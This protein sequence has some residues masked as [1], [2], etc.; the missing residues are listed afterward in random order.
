MRSAVFDMK[1]V[2]LLVYAPREAMCIAPAASLC[3]IFE[4]SSQKHHVTFSLQI[5]RRVGPRRRYISMP[6]VEAR[7]SPHA[8]RRVRGR[9]VL[10]K[11]ATVRNMV[12]MTT[13][14]LEKR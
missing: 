8:Q 4:A 5:Q 6:R 9:P 12:E 10:L 14:D 2:F 11:P 7:E 3:W 1:D 13:T